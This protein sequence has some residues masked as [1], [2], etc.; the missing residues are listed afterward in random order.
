MDTIF[1]KLLNMSIT[2]SWI[3]LAIILFRIIFKK[4]PKAIVVGIWAL[5]GIR[6]LCPFSFES[7]F[8]LIPSVDTV[9]TD[10]IYAESPTINSGITSF[11]TVVNPIISESLAPN[12]GDSVNPIQVI[13]Y[14]SSTVWLVGMAIMFIYILI[15][16]VLIH[17]K[18]RE[19]TPLEDN[20]WLCDRINTPFIFGIIRPRIYIPSYIE[21]Q[22]ME[23]VIAHEKAHL[24]RCDHLWKLIGYLLLTVYWFNPI[25]WVAYILLCRDIELACD[26]KVV[27]EK[28]I[29]IKKAYS[30]ALI[31]CSATRRSLIACPLAFGEIGVKGRI[32]FVLN[33]K[34]P[35]FWIV[36][37]CIFICILFSIVFLTNPPTI[38][39]ELKEFLDTQIA[40]HNRSYEY[41]DYIYCLDWDVIGIEKNDVNT[42]V[43]AWVMYEEYCTEKDDI[44]LGYGTQIPTVITV[45]EDGRFKITEYWEPR[46][47]SYYAEDMRNKLPWYLHIKANNLYLPL[48]KK[49]SKNSQKMADEYFKSISSDTDIIN[50]SNTT[51]RTITE[52]ME[53][54]P[55]YFGMGTDKGLWVYVA[56]TSKDNYRC[57]LLQGRNQ[58]YSSYDIWSFR[59]KSTSIEEMKLILSTYDIDRDSISIHAYND[60]TSSYYTEI[61]DAYIKE[62][63]KLFWDY[64]YDGTKMDLT[65]KDSLLQ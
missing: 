46:S 61:N 42:T 45:K 10:I 35:T 41:I 48:A 43:Y 51:S 23:Y 55:L 31:N 53:E 36:S 21:E 38:S 63:E 39:D 29:E 13:V 59:A 27:K 11:N 60:P 9:P 65:N 22:D 2:A 5:V 4:A 17:I 18:L 24:K 26:E 52:L 32:K 64:S 47:G 3:V 28:G 34:K 50:F 15:S 62:L 58:M 19:A 8:S 49:H 44:Y 40:L 7:I 30:N 6:L 56:Q 33:Y 37:A 14:L 16:S 54:Y 57:V 12:V 25:L 1:L 20:I